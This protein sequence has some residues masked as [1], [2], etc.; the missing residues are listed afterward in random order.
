MNK[1]FLVY[2]VIVC[3]KILLVFGVVQLMVISM[4]W[5][6]RKIMA[7]MQVRLGP[8]RVG[9]HGLLQPIADGIKLLFKEDIIPEKASKLLFVL[10]PAMAMVP[11]ML[12]FAV[13]PFGDA[14][15]IL[16]YKVDLVITDVNIGFLYIFGVSSLGIYGIVMAGW[17]SNNKYSLLGGIRSSAQMISYELTLGLSLIGVVMMTESLSLVDV[18]NAQAKLWNIILQPIGFFIYFTSAIA[19]VNR[20]PFDLPEAESELVAGYHTEYSSMKFAMFFMAEYANMITVSAIAV[21]FFLGGWQ[22]PFLPPV[23]WF[24]LK[25]SGCLFFFI[26][27]RSTFPRLRYD[28]L[29]HFG[30]KFLL[31]LSLFNILITGLVIVIKG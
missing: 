29:M 9:P 17:A 15:K 14:V 4:I 30:W 23:V 18:V 2:L 12:T 25:L 8:M 7:H 20:C 26:W 28:Q 5:L 31:P 11:A 21:T 27:I 22:G 16:G 6:E 24:L 1:E 13:I 10:A 19:E 3:V